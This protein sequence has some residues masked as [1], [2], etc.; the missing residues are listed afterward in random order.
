[1]AENLTEAAVAVTSKRTQKKDAEKQLKAQ[2]DYGSSLLFI[3]NSVIALCK[4]D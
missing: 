2:N 4:M 1:M 3:S